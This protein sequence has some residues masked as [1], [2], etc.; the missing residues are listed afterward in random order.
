MH[1]NAQ[2]I[3]DFLAAAGTEKV[4]FQLKDPASQGLLLPADPEDDTYLYRY[5]V[6]PMRM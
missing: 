5:V 1:F 4:E 2:Y 3:L 6:M